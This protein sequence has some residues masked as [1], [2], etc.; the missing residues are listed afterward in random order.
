[1]AYRFGFVM[2][3]TLGQITHTQNFQ[4]WI[5]R[6]ADVVPTWMLISYEVRGGWASV[7][8][9]GRNWTVQASVRARAAVR[10]ALRTQD[11]DALFFHTQVTALFAHGLMQRIPTVVSM[12]ATPLNFDVI[13]RHYGHEP[14][15]SGRVESLKNTLTR[16]SFTRARELVIWHQLG[17]KS[18]VEDYGAPPEKVAVIPPGIDLE[19]WNFPRPRPSSSPAVRLLFV[20]GDFK[21]KGGDILLA[22]FRS[23]LS[24]TCELD[25]VT[26]EE[27]DTSGLANVRVHRGL[28]PNAPELRALFAQADV[29]VFPT[30]GDMFPLAVME[31]MASGLPVIAANVGALGEQVRDGVTGLLIPPNDVESLIAAARR[32]VDDPGLRQR[33]GDEGRRIADQEFNGSRNYQRILEIMKRAASR[34]VGGRA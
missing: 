8:V 13:G 6:D 17:K 34:A 22:A 25:I 18:L 15:T 7:P 4:H 24:A 30:L 14:S 23:A 26:R 27:V 19:R 5:G 1:M 11:F 31:A 29:F 2:E 10:K 3:Q 12:D 16:R 33:M 21:R 28:G 32:L 20:G 9:I